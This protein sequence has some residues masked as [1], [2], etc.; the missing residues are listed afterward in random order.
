MLQLAYTSNAAP[1]LT[2]DEV[3][4]IIETSARNNL[5]EGLTGFLVM[6]AGRFFQ[7]VEGPQ[8]AIDALFSR[9]S[10]DSRHSGIAILFRENI[11]DRSF[12]KWQMKRVKLDETYLTSG[13]A[14]G[15][16]ATIPPHIRKLLMEFLNSHPA[17]A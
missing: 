7:V 8:T 16:I 5:G 10:N 2:S 17:A 11:S 4:K 12:P 9:L 1:N 13:H 14:I 6:S 3:F 15:D